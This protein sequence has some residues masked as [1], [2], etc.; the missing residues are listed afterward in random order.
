[1]TDES[2]RFTF[3]PIGVIYSPYGR[4]IDA[5]H[6]GTVVEGT[7]TGEAA[8]AS[9]EIAEWLDEKSLQDLEGFERVWLIFVFHASEGWKTSVKPPRGGPKRG[10]LATRSPHRPNAISLSAVELVAVEE[11]E[12]LPAARKHFGP[13]DWAVLDAAFGA[14]ADPLTGHSAQ[15]DYQPLFQRILNHAPAPVG[16][17]RILAQDFGGVESLRAVGEVALHQHHG[18]APRVAGAAS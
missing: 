2:S 12:I 13:D 17:G 10:V 14:N 9:L 4:R 1:M 18:V 6:Q 3:R 16:L 5:P 15:P 8:N 7:Q 11:T